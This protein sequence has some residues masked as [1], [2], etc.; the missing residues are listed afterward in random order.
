[1]SEFK[2]VLFLSVSEAASIGAG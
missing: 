1:M 2:R